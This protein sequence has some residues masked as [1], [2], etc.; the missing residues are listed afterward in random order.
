MTFIPDPDAPPRAPRP[1]VWQRPPWVWLP[2]AVRRRLIYTHAA[3]I[4]VLIGRSPRRLARC[5]RVEP[6]GYGRR[7]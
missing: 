5:P 1:I 3:L 7:P 4:M 6:P 2:W